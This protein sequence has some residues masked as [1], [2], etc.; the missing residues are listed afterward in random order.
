METYNSGMARSACVNS[1]ELAM[2][3][4]M[5]AVVLS[6]QTACPYDYITQNEQWSQDPCCNSVLS[7]SFWNFSN[8]QETHHYFS[9]YLVVHRINWKRLYH[10]TQTQMT[11]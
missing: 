7:V 3:S 2:E 1:A 11:M 9:Q 6:D 4:A 10:N 5:E 8:F